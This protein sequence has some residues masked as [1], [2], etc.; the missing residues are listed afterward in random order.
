MNRGA[1]RRTA[2]RTTLRTALS[3]AVHRVAVG[4]VI[5]FCEWATVFATMY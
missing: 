4:V 2:L 1:L 3:T 5:F